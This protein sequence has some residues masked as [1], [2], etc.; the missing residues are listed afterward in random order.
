MEAVIFM[1]GTPAR[2]PRCTRSTVQGL[3]LA[4]PPRKK[5]SDG[6]FYGTNTEIERTQEER[7]LS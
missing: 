5:A 2:R 6:T 3:Q 1:M 7:Y 4:E